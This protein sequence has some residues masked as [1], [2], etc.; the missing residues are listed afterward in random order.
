MWAIPA[1]TEAGR[2]AKA[3]VAICCVLDWRELDEEVGWRT[4][5]I[6]VRD[7]ICFGIGALP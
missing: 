3:G 7:A 1:K 4:V 5:E 6:V 2:Q